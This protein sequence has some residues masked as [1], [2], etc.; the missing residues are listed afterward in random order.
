M[1]VA[2]QEWRMK[3]EYFKDANRDEVM[4]LYRLSTCGNLVSR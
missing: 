1:L 3:S 4:K 2:E